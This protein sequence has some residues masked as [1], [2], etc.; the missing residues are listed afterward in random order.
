MRTSLLTQIAPENR[1][2]HRLGPEAR[3]AR[4]AFLAVSFIQR[5]GMK[6]LFKSLRALLDES[7]PV[8]VYT[9]GYL[10]ITDPAA[11]DDLLRLS[12]H[13]RSLQ[14]FFNPDDRFHSKFFFFDKPADRYSLFLG[15]SNVSVGGFADTGELN[16]HIRG[17]SVDSVHRDIQIVIGNLRNN[18]GFRPLTSDL[19]S[20]YR[21]GMSRRTT[22]RRPVSSRRPKITLRL[23]EMPVYVV[24]SRFTERDCKRIEGE[25]PEWDNYVS[26]APRL[27]RLKSGDHFLCISKFRGEKATFTTTRYVEHDRVAGVGMVA[28]VVDGDGLP[29][30]RLAKHLKIDEKALAWMKAL[31]VYGVAILRRDFPQTFG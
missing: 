26:Y 8:A 17:K 30:A 18:R 19:I 14:V 6:H 9:S 2:L 15:S 16:V 11:L 1:L 22:V 4:A 20:D 3:T 10:G 7:R 29:L 24:D 5:A 12:S 13:Y 25:H 28:C 23:D 31:D 27:R 21:K